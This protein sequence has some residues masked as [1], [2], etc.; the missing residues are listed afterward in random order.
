MSLPGLISL[1]TGSPALIPAGRYARCG[2]KYDWPDNRL[3]I[4]RAG[5][6]HTCSIRTVRT[7]WCWGANWVGE[8]GFGTSEERHVSTRAGSATTLITVSGTANR[9][10]G[11]QSSCGA[12]GGNAH[13]ELGDGTTR[14]T[15]PSV[16][17]VKTSTMANWLT[18]STN[19]NNSCGIRTDH[20]IWC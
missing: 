3:A 8:L 4:G 7:L 17:P 11:V 16:G 13:G 12:G 15:L 1:I 5:V 14:S 9:T 18:V 2:G 6:D 20:T 19:N 10:C